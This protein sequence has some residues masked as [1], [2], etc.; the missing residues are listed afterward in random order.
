M[1]NSKLQPQAHLFNEVD[2][3]RNDLSFLV[4]DLNGTKYKISVENLKE[5]LI[6]NSE[7]VNAIDTLDIKFS[8]STSSNRQDL[9]VLSDSLNNLLTNN[10]ELISKIDKIEA[11]LD[12]NP[13]INIQ[14]L[15]VLVTPINILSDSKIEL[16]VDKIGTVYS[17]GDR[18]RTLTRNGW[19]TIKFE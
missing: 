17:D 18:I 14:D 12:S 11:K 9:I 2:I 19:K 4:F 16:I 1:D 3:T 6:D 13:L 8:S 15:L 10:N 7:L 5:L